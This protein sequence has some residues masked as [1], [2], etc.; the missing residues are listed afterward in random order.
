MAVVDG[1]A[2]PG[3]RLAAGAAGS[4]L[5]T[6]GGFGVG[7]L[8]RAF[9]REPGWLGV[10][11]LRAS[12]LSRAVCTLLAVAGVLLLLRSWLALRGAP[13]A[14]QLRAAA[15]WSLPLLLAPPLFSRDLYAYA[16][17]GQQIRMGADP[18]RLG[19]VT[20][21]GPLS[22]SV[23]TQWAGSASPYGPLFLLLARLVVGLVGPRPEAAVLLL[24]LVAVAG[25]LLVAWALVRLA[26]HDAGPALWLG[27]ANP[28]VLLHGVGGGH[29]ETL[30]AGLMLAGLAV[31]LG[32]ARHGAAWQRCLGAGLVTLGA[33]V[34]LPALVA[35]A[36][37]PDRT[38]TR[39]LVRQAAAVGA[40]AVVVAWL[41]GA[42]TG[43]G[44]GWLRT[45]AQGGGN[46][47]VLTPVYALGHLLRG[48]GV[49]D[50]M[51]V[52]RTAATLAGIA[53]AGAVLLAAPRLGRL[54]ALGWALVVLACAAPQLQPWYLLWGLF[55]L[56]AT[57]GERTRRALTA[58]SVV[59][60][61]SVLPGGTAVLPMADWGLPG[62]LAVVAGA[63]AWRRTPAG[64]GGD[65][66]A[67]MTGST[68]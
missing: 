44:P 55:P 49:A 57:G 16:A 15:L 22:D 67:R 56:A 52:G 31:G 48:V 46:A 60:C 13:A 62:L 66:P 11:L 12:A 36:V 54:P 1:T 4:V 25:L 40:V 24:R 7:A 6:V 26:P 59:L 17:Q 18:Y 9:G 43:L 10:D 39:T 20:T 58:A 5:L 63:V 33:V 35:L 21:P 68:P 41:A 14:V 30:M 34:K 19:P 23:S 65:R 53:L 61:L 50:G 29:N 37:L 45:S 64:T 27:L 42:V 3:R 8:P 47:R 2:E 38:P 51:A 32:P 28:L